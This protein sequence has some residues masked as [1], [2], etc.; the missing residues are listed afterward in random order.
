VITDPVHDAIDAARR[1]EA[2]FTSALQVDDNAN[3]DAANEALQRAYST[4]PTTPAGI[5]ALARL[6]LDTEDP[7][8]VVADALA[9]IE[10]AALR[11]AGN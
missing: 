4:T 9:S 7:E 11:L 10:A 6:V 3:G 1:A 2:A 8:P 5:A